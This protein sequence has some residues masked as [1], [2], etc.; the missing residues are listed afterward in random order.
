ATT[1]RVMQISRQAIYRT[2]APRRRPVR[3]ISLD[4]IDT[5]IVETAK[6]NRPGKLGGVFHWVTTAAR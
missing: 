6:V 1:A 4:E 2:P 3:P 5:A